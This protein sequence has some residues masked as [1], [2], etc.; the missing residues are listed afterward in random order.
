LNHRFGIIGLFIFLNGKSVASKK[1]NFVMAKTDPKV[2]WSSYNP[3]NSEWV[4]LPA[5]QQGDLYNSPI[6]STRA[7]PVKTGDAKPW[8]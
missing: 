8:I 6:I 5:S 1:P 4:D 2:G 3:V 7:N